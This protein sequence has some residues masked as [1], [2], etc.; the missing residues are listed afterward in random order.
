ME[1]DPNCGVYGMPVLR[2]WNSEKVFVLKHT[3]TNTSCT[4]MENIISFKPNADVVLGN[5]K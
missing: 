5:S 4:V 2:A 3:I 1:D